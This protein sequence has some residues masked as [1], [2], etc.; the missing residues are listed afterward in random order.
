LIPGALA[1]SISQVNSHYY[2]GVGRFKVNTT[3]GFISLFFSL[4]AAI[5]Y[6]ISESILIP[7]LI[8]SGSAIVAMIYFVRLFLKEKKL[9]V[10]DI[11]PGPTDIKAMLHQFNAKVK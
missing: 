1:S 6:F 9:K 8:I 5:I 11:I 10:I 3:A 2:T 4:T 7:G